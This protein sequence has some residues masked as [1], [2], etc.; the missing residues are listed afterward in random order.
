MTTTTLTPQQ[1][2]QFHREGFLALQAITTPEDVAHIR[3]L[4]DGLFARFDELPKDLALDLG[5]VK[6]H[7]G[8]QRTP[9]INMASQFEPRLKE[10]LYFRNAQ[11]V[12][13]QLLGQGASSSWDHAILKPPH[14]GRETPWHQ[15][16][17]Y[18]SHSS[19]NWE[20]LRMGCNFWM[21][22][23]DATVESG[24]MQFIPHSHLGNLQP[25]HPVGHD[26]R[27][28]TLMTDKADASKAV[29]CP[30][31]AGGCTIHLPKT[32]HYT[33]PNDTDIPRRTYILFF[34]VPLA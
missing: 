18:P 11:A 7:G 8:K 17:S 29:P 12:A 9:Q 27:V 22:L 14:N 33:A 19:G 2:V 16:L 21:P 28:H 20:L 32:M 4:L 6:T 5:D 26:P 30:I 31:P 13:E 3:E 10:T 34:G 15:D 23:Q 24:C 1:I 25:H